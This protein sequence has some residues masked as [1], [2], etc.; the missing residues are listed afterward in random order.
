MVIILYTKTII[1]PITNGVT[2]PLDC[3]LS[4]NTRAIVKTFNNIQSNIVLI[5]ELICYEL[6]VILKLPIPE[7]GICIIDENTKG[8]NYIEKSQFGKGFYS[9]RINKS[10]V[11]NGYKMFQM[12]KNKD[13][14]L[15][16]ILF[17]H[18]IYNTDRNQGNLLAC[19]AQKQMLL[20]L[21]D[22]T[23]VFNKQCLWDKHQLEQCQ[24][25]NDYR[26]TTI[27]EKNSFL[28]SMF[29]NVVPKR[30]DKLLEISNSYKSK[31]NKSILESI[32]K[33]IPIEW[34]LSSNNANALIDYLLYRLDKLDDICNII[35]SN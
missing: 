30:L 5:N 17:D 4:D 7:A 24:Q 9:K 34:E 8:L 33:K 12:I 20:M 18:L 14:L 13:D 2:N 28:Y 19:F 29:F 6:A 25:E 16:T 22:H 10:T 27:L 11:F 35:N 26:D 15:K 3:E 31:I 1:S 23:H 21:I 32:I